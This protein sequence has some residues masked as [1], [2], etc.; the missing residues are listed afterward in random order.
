MS[1]R[2]FRASRIFNGYRFIDDH[3]LITNS[4]GVVQELIPDSGEDAETADGI[5]CPGF[6]N[7]HCHLELSHMKG[8]IPEKTGLVDFVY[9]IV[10]ERQ[11]SPEWIAEAIAAAESE[12][13]ANGI[14][15]VGDICN[16]DSTIEQKSK[17]RLAYYNFIEV[18][19]W[20]PSVV[21]SRLG[22]AI[23]LYKE[24]IRLQQ[25][26]AIVPHAPYSVATVLWDEMERLYAG[27]VVS[28][29]NQETAFEDDFFR[30]GKGDFLRMYEKMK[31]SNSH[32]LPS[33]R[34]SL[35]TYYPRM[36][37]AGNVILVHNTFI[38]EDDINFVKERPD[39]DAA[40]F[41]CI[42]INANR[43]IEDSL[44]PVDLLRKRRCNIVLGT[45]S[46]ASNHSLNLLEEIKTI[47]KFFPE[48]PLE[49]MLCWA[50]SRG[51]R[52]LGMQK[53]LGSFEPGRKPGVLLLDHEA[54][55]VKRL[56]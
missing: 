25:P 5:L 28:I 6:V 41:Y 46:L 47:R 9:A 55:T 56:L 54:T 39:D 14:V 26:S 45:D 27:K 12:M 7:C 2:K 37:T 51:A 29:H 35:Q 48:V 10:T 13:I 31:I 53:T 8:R 30:E 19:G 17:K 20:Q 49:E 3:L 23:R 16:N 32:H 40:T 42:C 24:F 44:P 50:T 33:G 52:A 38:S 34:S 18:S 4:T 15:A 21:A 22:N 43:Y 36:R 11:H 1:L